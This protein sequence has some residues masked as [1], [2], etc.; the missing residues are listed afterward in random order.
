MPSKGLLGAPD[1]AE[2]KVDRR[3]HSRILRGAPLPDLKTKHGGLGSPSCCTAHYSLARVGSTK[4][5]DMI[6]GIL[7]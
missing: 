5:T 4:H 3:D 7:W 6:E 2:S 1:A